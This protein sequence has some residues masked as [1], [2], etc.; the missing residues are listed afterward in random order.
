MHSNIFW[1]YADDDKND[2]EENKTTID[3]DWKI[4]DNFLILIKTINNA[5]LYAEFADALIPNHKTV[6]ADIK[7]MTK[8]GLF[9]QEYKE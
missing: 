9:N 8:P 1:I 3:F 6:D 5:L 2:L 4:I 7:L